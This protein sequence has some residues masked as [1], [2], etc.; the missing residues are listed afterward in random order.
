MEALILVPINVIYMAFIVLEWRG[1][2]ITQKAFGKTEPRLFPVG[3]LG[4]LTVTLKTCDS[5]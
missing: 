2:L 1:V 3:V 5:S 4:R